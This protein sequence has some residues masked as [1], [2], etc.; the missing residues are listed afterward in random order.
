MS[1]IQGDLQSLFKPLA[2][3]VSHRLV[4][5]P[6]PKERVCVSLSFFGTRRQKYRNDVADFVRLLESNPVRG[7]LSKIH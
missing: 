2:I 1:S 5:T 7:L 4:R 3:V 6:A